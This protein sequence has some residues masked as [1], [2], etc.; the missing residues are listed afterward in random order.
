VTRLRLFPAFRYGNLPGGPALVHD[1]FGGTPVDAP[2]SY[3]AWS[4]AA[5][6][7]PGCPPVLQVVG[8]HDAIIPPSQGRLLHESLAR[9]GGRSALVEI[10][11]AVHGF[12]QYP[13]VSRR[14]APAARR[15]TAP[16]LAFL[17]D[18]R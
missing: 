4:P 6:V 17:D 5:L 16:L 15:T 14:I 9:A 13:G 1:L 2:D 10:P 12:D 11:M 18:V 8:H 3:A 7:G